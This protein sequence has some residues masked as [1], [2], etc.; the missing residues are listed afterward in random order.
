MTL[1]STLEHRLTSKN[2]YAL[3]VTPPEHDALIQML[4]TCT[5]DTTPSPDTPP[6][7]A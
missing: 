6:E 1:T 4:D 2:V 3:S 7:G 5:A